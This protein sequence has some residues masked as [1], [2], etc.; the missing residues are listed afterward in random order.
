MSRIFSSST[1]NVTDYASFAVWH[2]AN[3]K[4][5]RVPSKEQVINEQTRYNPFDQK[6]DCF[7]RIMGQF[8]PN[9]GERQDISW[10]EIAEE[11][12]SMYQSFADYGTD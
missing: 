6:K 10:R 5:Y 4:G 8:A 7:F 9:P 2:A 12:A 11:Y 3:I 1:Q